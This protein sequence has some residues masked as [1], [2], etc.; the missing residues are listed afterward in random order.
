MFIVPISD[1]IPPVKSIFERTP[2]VQSAEQQ[3]GFKSLFK[4]IFAE[5]QAAGVNTADD[6]IRMVNGEIDDLHTL[7][8]NATKAAISVEAFVAVK[9]TTVEAFERIMNMQI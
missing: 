1:G 8:N 2:T 4:E 3:E 6:N 5:A 7:Y 9:N